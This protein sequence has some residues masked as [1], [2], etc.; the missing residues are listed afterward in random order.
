MPEEH[1]FQDEKMYEL[2]LSSKHKIEDRRDEINK[3]YTTLFA[4]IISLIP[5]FYNLLCKEK[6]SEDIY[7]IRLCLLLLSLVNLMLSISWIKTLTRIHNYVEGVDSLL[8]KIE[9]K[10]NQSFIKY[11]SS[12][13]YNMGSPGRVTKQEMLIP[14]TF[15]II[16][17]LGFAYALFGNF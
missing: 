3:Y 6:T 12:Y 16:F 14:R 5:F 4:A 10:H 17:S 13:L 7:T 2:I 1:R 8:V 9:E 11:I 15:S